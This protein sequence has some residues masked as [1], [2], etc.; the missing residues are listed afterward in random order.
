MNVFHS[1]PPSAAATA[2]I[3]YWVDRTLQSANGQGGSVKV[4]KDK[5]GDSFVDYT[6]PQG[7]EYEIGAK[8]GKAPGFSNFT[9][10]P[11]WFV[12]RN[13]QWQLRDDLAI[14]EIMRAIAS[15]HGDLVRRR[16]ER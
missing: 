11:N 7:D 6:D 2:I 12:Q 9:I 3:F 1:G 14:R 16:F 15:I 5:W 8:Y 4:A 13:N 10:D